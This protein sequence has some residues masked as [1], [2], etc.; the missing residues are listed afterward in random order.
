LESVI[1]LLE[2]AAGIGWLPE[3]E[4]AVASKRA[5]IDASATFED[6]SKYLD[7]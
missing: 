7:I 6:W 2:E 4:H 5:A 3:L 1:G